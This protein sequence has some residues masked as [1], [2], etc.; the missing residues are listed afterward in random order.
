MG[1]LR[2]APGLTLGAD[3]LRWAAGMFEGEGTVTIA[4]RGRDDTYRVVVILGNTDEQVVD[5]F[6]QRWG[7]W[8]QPAYGS[9][10]GRQPAWYWTAAGPGAEV[11][12]RDIRPYLRTD[13]VRRKVELALGFRDHQSRS[14][15][16]QSDPRYKERQRELYAQMRILN[17]RGVAA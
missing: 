12:L 3:D 5:F 15:R 2:L 16:R 14:R 9:R 1:K 7:Y 11:F 6:Y 17:R 10:E 13:R 8:K 4:R